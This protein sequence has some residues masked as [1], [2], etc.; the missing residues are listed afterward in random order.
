MLRPQAHEPRRAEVPVQGLRLRLQM[1]QML[2]GPIAF[3]LGA[4]GGIGSA[5]VR[6]LAECGAAVVIGYHRSESAA[7]DLLASLPGSNHIVVQAAVTDSA[8]LADL[9][10]RIGERYGC[11]D[12]LVN[13]AGTTRFVP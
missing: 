4:S 5:I 13:C 3:V 8:G 12:L 2:R 6:R 10:M 7:L 11:L 9:A 1:E